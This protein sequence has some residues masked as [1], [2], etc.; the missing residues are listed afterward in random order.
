MKA[1]F[2][3][4]CKNLTALPEVEVY[5]ELKRLGWTRNSIFKKE[6]S[7]TVVV[8]KEGTLRNFNLAENA[9]I[10]EQYVTV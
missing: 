2:K 8:D 10:K 7:N 5:E 1:V 4:F 3:D 9:Q 6:L